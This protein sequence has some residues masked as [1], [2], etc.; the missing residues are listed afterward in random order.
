MTPAAAGK[1]PFFMNHKFPKEG[2]KLFINFGRS[3]SNLICPLSGPGGVQV[4]HGFPPERKRQLL[5][6]KKTNYDKI[7]IIIIKIAHRQT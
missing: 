1:K 4:P 7:I 2:S 6:E 3:L 5:T